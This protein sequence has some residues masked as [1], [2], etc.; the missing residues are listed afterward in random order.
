VLCYTLASRV[1]FEFGGVFAL[2]TQTVF[3]A[4]WFLLPAR[5][6]PVVVCASLLIAQ[7]PDLARRR[8]PIDRLALFVGASWFTIGPALILYLAGAHEPRWR[9]LPIY[10]AALGAHSSSRP[11]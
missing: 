8:M 5:M 7:L 3:V 9:S 2:P 10:V 1:Q 6:L 11:S 4:M